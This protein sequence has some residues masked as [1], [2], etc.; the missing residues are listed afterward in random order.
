MEGSK[1]NRVKINL[2]KL[3]QIIL[4]IVYPRVCPFCGVISKRGI[5]DT[6]KSTIKYLK[7]PRCF[8]CG[9]GVSAPEIEYCDDCNKMD[10]AFNQGKS[11]YVHSGKA[12]K[13]V[14]QYKFFNR[15]TFGE[16]FAMELADKFGDDVRRWGISLVVPIPLH[17]SKERERGF[18]QSGIIATYLGKELDIPVNH[19]LLFRVKKTNPQKNLLK[20]Q[21]M[22]NLKGAFGALK[23][24]NIK[25]NILLIDDIYTTGIT[26][27]KAAIVLKKAGAEKVYFLTVTIGE[28][29]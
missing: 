14:Y 22:E 19:N 29:V 15:R 12:A 28:K 11:L 13:A 21:R 5:C 18:N 10:F 9:R 1:I 20:N 16:D 27:H 24:Q 4:D 3:G 26:I 2:K 8:R 25:G 17:S 7:E 6:C 23:G